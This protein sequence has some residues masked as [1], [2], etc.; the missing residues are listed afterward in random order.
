MLPF[1]LSPP[2]HRTRGRTQRKP[3]EYT[4][5]GVSL[6]SS[7]YHLITNTRYKWILPLGISSLRATQGPIIWG[8]P[9]K[10]LLLRSTDYTL[11]LGVSVRLAFEWMDLVK[12][13]TPT[14][15]GG[16]H[17]VCWGPEWNTRWRRKE[18]VP[19]PTVHSAELWVFSR[20][21]TGIP[22]ISSPGSQVCGLRLQWHHR[23]SIAW[24]SRWGDFTVSII[25]WSFPY[26][27]I[28]YILLVLFLWKNSE[29]YI[30][31]QEYNFRWK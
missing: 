14:H 11:F 27:K 23:V 15:M 22:T 10:C 3:G 16:F 2:I 29:W 13:I 9:E 12:E 26:N 20:P 21:C 6:W 24:D 4:V 25:T 17:P 31:L 1:S 7:T 8:L 19:L 18:S 28:I 5:Q 30:D